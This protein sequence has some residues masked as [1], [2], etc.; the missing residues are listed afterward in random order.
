MSADATELYDRLAEVLTETPAPPCTGDDR[1]TLELS[2]LA[3]N[4][5]THLGFTVCMACPIKPECIAYAD[6]ARPP[7]GVWAGRTYPPR[8]RARNATDDEG[9]DATDTLTL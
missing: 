2:E 9:V 1:L 5:A 8:G 3:P 6:A 7:V 4:E